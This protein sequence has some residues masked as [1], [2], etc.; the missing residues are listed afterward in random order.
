MKKTIK[1]VTLLS[2]LALVTAGCGGSKKDTGGSTTSG[3]D[4]G[5]GKITIGIKYDQPGLGVMDGNTP[6][7][8]DIEVAK[9]VAAEAGFGEDAIEWKESISANRE[10]M[11][12]TGEVDL[13]VATYSIT[14][15]RKQR[16][17]FAGPYLVAGQDLL[18]TKDNSD[19]TGPDSL[20]GKRLCS[21]QGSTPAA[22]IKEEYSKGVDLVERQTYSE[23]MDALVSGQIDALTTDDSI[24]AGFAAQD[25]YKDQVKLV[26]KPFSEEYYGIGLPKEKPKVTCENVNKALTKMFDDGKWS[27]ALSENLGSYKPN[28]E[29]N[30]PHPTLD[31]CG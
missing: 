1:I 17:A 3:D 21:V 8:F 7:G 15:D 25:A 18:V 19:I 28:A 12:E 4:K 11:L 2:C 22:R 23:C 10:T 30:E 13:I 14:D 6:K 27:K 24:L 29:F 5:G 9:Y 31:T 16:V 26:G 20:D